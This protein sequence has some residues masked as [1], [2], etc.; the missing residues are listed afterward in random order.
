LNGCLGGCL[1]RVVALIF[2]AIIVIVAWRFGPGVMEEVGFGRDRPGEV[3]PEAGARAV[4]RYLELV[5]G[6]AESASFSGPELESILRFHAPHALPPGVTDP[7]VGIHDGELRL[8]V[9]VSLALLPRIPELEGVWHLLPDSVPVEFRGSL[10][11]LEGSRAALIVRRIDVA[12]VPIP[13]AFHG[14]LVA[15]LEAE[16]SEGLPEE[17]ITFPLPD[18]IRSAEVHGDELVLRASGRSAAIHHPRSYA[19]SGGPWPPS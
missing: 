8:G 15:A 18:G 13:R 3:S 7:S 5:G 17:S 1:G 12:A 9:R 16:R 2:L 10:V 4:D 14:R 11:P 19:S 6:T